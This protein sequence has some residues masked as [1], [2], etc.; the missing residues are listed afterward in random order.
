[1]CSRISTI[2]WLF[3]YHPDLTSIFA[4]SADWAQACGMERK[5]TSVISRVFGSFCLCGSVPVCVGEL[6]G[7]VCRVRSVNI[8]GCCVWVGRPQYHESVLFLKSF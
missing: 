7:A 2:S 4:S 5:N 1:M 3:V 6:V 8:L